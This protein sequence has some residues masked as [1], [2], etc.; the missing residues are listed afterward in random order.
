LGRVCGHAVQI[1]CRLPGKFS[2]AELS[3][4]SNV[5]PTD[6]A[7]DV[8]VRVSDVESYAPSDEVV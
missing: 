6:T 8:F 7:F 2:G 1:E 3:Y 4:E 5:K